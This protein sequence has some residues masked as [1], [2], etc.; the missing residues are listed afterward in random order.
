MKVFNI[1]FCVLFLVSA[2]LQYNDVDPY[3]WVPL[4]GYGAWVCYIAARGR[5]PV[6]A[7]VLGTVVYLAFAV[8]YLIFK[9]GVLEWFEFHEARDLVHSMQAD[10]PW[11]EETRE[12][13]GLGI[14]AAVMAINWVAAARYRRSHSE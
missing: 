14:L 12:L 5:H 8:Y 13:G 3:L 6:G 2:G 7:S 1:V 10:K 11:I 9:H 4:Y